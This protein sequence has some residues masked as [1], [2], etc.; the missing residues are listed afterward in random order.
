MDRY[1]R[2]AR[3]A[4]IEFPQ[5]VAGTQDYGHKLRV[6]LRDKSFIDVFISRKAKSSWFAFHWERRQIDN[7]IYRIDSAPDTRWKK[8]KTFPIHFHDTQER[9]VGEPPF[10]FGGLTKEQVFREFLRFAEEK[11]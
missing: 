10:A 4:E 1:S 8:V 11:I 3:I 9:K 5:I 7:T 6:Y 2:F